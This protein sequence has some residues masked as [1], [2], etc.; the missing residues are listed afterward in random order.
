MSSALQVGI[1]KQRAVYENM[2]KPLLAQLAEVHQLTVR[3]IGEIFGISKSYAADILQ[4]RRFPPLE[5][6]FRLARYFE[7]TVEELFGWRLSDDGMRRPLLVDV[8]GT[9][10]RLSSVNPKH[11]AIPLALALSEVMQGVLDRNRKRREEAGDVADS[12]H[13]SV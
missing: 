8:G 6:A 13:S 4:H 5:L 1:E 10:V 2:P 9:V 12:L 3:D 7:V 11:K